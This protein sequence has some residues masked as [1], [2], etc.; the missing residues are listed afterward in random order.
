MKKIIALFILAISFGT[1]GFSQNN[2]DIFSN[3]VKQ[4]IVA[5]IINNT[6]AV[7]NYGRGEAVSLI[8]T[9]SE[10]GYT[11]NDGWLKSSDITLDFYRN[12]KGCSNW[13][14]FTVKLAGVD[15]GEL[16]IKFGN[17]PDCEADTDE[18]GTISFIPSL[19]KRNEPVRG[20]W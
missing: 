4:L 16:H 6:Q 9:K 3:K 19:R 17:D 10:L 18:Q 14:L 15:V 7:D 20:G 13:N 2:E 11:A 8:A 5:S 1:A 12:I